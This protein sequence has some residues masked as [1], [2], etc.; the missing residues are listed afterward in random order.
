MPDRAAIVTGASSGIGLAIA[1]VLAQEGHALTISARR[2]DKLAGAAEALAR[3]VAKI[4]AVAGTLREE[5]E[6]RR[7]VPAPGARYGR[8]AVLV[9]CAGVG[10]GAPLA[11]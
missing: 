1:Q 5:D 9:N 11:E 6:V 10:V 7:M 3:L 8:L 4:E 2:P